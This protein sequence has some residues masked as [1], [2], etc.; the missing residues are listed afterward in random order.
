VFIHYGEG[1]YFMKSLLSLVLFIMLSG[2]D[3]ISQ[4]TQQPPENVLNEYFDALTNQDY[5]V[6][7][8]KLSQSDVNYSSLADYQTTFT[9]DSP[10][11]TIFLANT[12]YVVQSVSPAGNNAV[13]IVNKTEPDAAKIAQEFMAAAFTSAFSG[14]SDSNDLEQAFVE[15][16]SQGNMPLKTTQEQY[17]LVKQEDGW[18]VFVDLRGIDERKAREEKIKTMLSDA[19]ALKDNRNY[20]RAVEIYNEILTEDEN[21]TEAIEAL[22]ETESEI[23]EQKEKQDYIQFV[24]LFDFEARRIDTYSDKGLPAVTFAVKNEGNRTLNKVEVTVYFKDENGNTFFEEDYFPVLVSSYSLSNNKPLKPNYVQR[25]EKGKYYTIKELGDEWKA[26]AAEALV[27][28]I[29]FAPE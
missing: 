9:D 11:I 28:D 27:T 19:E 24:T 16:Y 17:N 6:A 7:Y 26:G 25:Q 15:K 21:N 12:N 18:R 2:C 29:E 4:I 13:A 3:Q 23:A 1:K 20:V 5:A 8:S 22:N 10:F 14:N